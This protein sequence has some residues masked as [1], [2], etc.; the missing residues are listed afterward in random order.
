MNDKPSDDDYI[1]EL[2]ANGID[3]EI[4]GYVPS[5]LRIATG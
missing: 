4:L 2:R 3:P 5:R 1:D